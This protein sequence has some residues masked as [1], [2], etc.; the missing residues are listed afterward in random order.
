M[1]IKIRRDKERGGD[2]RE[3]R[4]WERFVCSCGIQPIALQLVVLLEVVL[5]VV[6]DVVVGV[7]LN[8]YY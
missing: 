1:G 2:R 3:T 5:E 7:L 4:R 6:L 8:L